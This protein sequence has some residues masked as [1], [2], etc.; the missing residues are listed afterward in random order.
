MSMKKQRP[1]FTLVEMLVVI[2]I[3]G[4]LIALLLPALAAARESAR[5]AQCKSNLRQF[6]VGMATFADRDPAQR[7]SSGAYDW[8]RDGCP[9]TYGW[10]ADLVNGGVCRPQELLC[11]SSQFKVSEKMNDFMGTTSIQPKEGLLDP[12]AD[13]RLPAGACALFGTYDPMTN[14]MTFSGTTTQ[15]GVLIADH[16]LGKGYGT[17][18]ASSW[19]MVRG[20]PRLI[21]TTAA[22]NT[23]TVTYPAG[24]APSA[25]KGLGGSTGPVTRAQCDAAAVP[26]SMIPLLFDSNVGDAREALLADN[27]IGSDGVGYG[28]A[29]QR[30]VESFSDGPVLNYG[31]AW[32]PGMVAVP[33]PAGGAAD[34]A[35][36][37]RGWGRTATG[38]LTVYAEMGGVVSSSVWGVEQPTTGISP[39]NPL[40]HLQDYRDIGP[41]HGT[42]KGGAA[43]VLFADGSVKSFTDTNGDGFLNPGF[44]IDVGDAPYTNTGYSDSTVELPTAQIFSGVF[45]QKQSGKGSLDL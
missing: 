42:G 32:L 23:V 5:Q 11:P 34:A 31:T 15:R 30:T 41:V 22:G 33:A 36:G 29:G 8:A 43:N 1:G 37:L 2:T 16:F 12:L 18:Y 39:V 14:V 4:I 21:S 17:N 35:D 20:A 45:L 6:Y 10:V 25:I 44:L 19:F 27:I 9:D 7:Y 3:I 26:S 38:V 24:G 40:P 28:V 13:Q